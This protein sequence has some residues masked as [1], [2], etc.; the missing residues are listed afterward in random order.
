MN[1][2]HD[3]QIQ[4]MR[5]HLDEM[6]SQKTMLDIALMELS[7]ALEERL[8]AANPTLTV[9]EA[10]ANREEKEFY[11]AQIQERI[12]E[13]EAFVVAITNLENQ[14]RENAEH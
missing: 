9:D 1:G 4:E 5:R 8:R 11:E 2:E 12:R 13:R 7:K 6:K 3:E 10:D 14:L